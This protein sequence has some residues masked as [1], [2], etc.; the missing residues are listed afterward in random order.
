M[1]AFGLNNKVLLLRK[2]T[3]WR[4]SLQLRW[5]LV[6]SRQHDWSASINK[7]ITDVKRNNNILL[8]IHYMAEVKR[9]S[10]FCISCLWLFILIDHNFRHIQVFRFLLLKWLGWKWAKLWKLYLFIQCELRYEDM[11]SITFV[12]FIQSF[13]C[14]TRNSVSITLRHVDSAW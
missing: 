3:R 7:Y 5:N 13:R 1:L 9:Y 6:F 12:V 10:Y 8:T 2:M 11:H 4:V 14:F